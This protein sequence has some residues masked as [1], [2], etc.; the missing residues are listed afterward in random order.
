MNNEESV[1]NYGPWHENKDASPEEL[2][3]MYPNSSWGTEVEKAH[4][5][6]LYYSPPFCPINEEDRKLWDALLSAGIVEIRMAYKDGKLGFI[7]HKDQ[8]I[9]L[10]KGKF[11]PIESCGGEMQQKAAGW[12]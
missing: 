11:Y 2:K 3:K 10:E 7:P 6:I 9:T 8:T 12:L 1:P 5:A 4:M